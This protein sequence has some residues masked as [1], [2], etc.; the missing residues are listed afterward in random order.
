MDRRRH[1]TLILLTASAMLV[2]C[3]DRSTYV[4]QGRTGV[5][6]RYDGDDLQADLP[7]DVPVP[8]V[9]AAGEQVLVRRGHSI[10]A[11]ETSGQRGRVVGRPGGKRLHRKVEIHARQVPGATRVWVEVVPLGDEAGSRSILEDMLIRLGF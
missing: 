11:S 7:P 8:S 3:A 1:T 5:E 9:I 6:A 4:R 2:G 10:T